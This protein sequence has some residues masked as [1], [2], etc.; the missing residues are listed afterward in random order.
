MPRLVRGIH[1]SA[2]GALY[3]RAWIPRTS[4]GMTTGVQVKLLN[5]FR[6]VGGFP[7]LPND[8][9]VSGARAETSSLSPAS[10]GVVGRSTRPNRG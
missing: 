1:R 6:D 8:D 5:T 4:R 9:N 10:A 7:P 3:D 2:F